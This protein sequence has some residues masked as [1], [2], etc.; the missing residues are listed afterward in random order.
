M[1][2]FD[3]DKNSSNFPA[4][5]SG[6]GQILKKLLRIAEILM[7]LLLLTWTAARLPFAVRISGEYLRR[8]VNIVVS[9]LF[10]FLLSNAI[11]LVLFCKSRSL[12]HLHHGFQDYRQT[13]ID[14]CQDFIANA[15]YFAGESCRRGQEIVYQDKRTILEVT[16]VRARS[17]RRSQSVNSRRESG[18]CGRRLRRSET[19]IRRRVGEE[20]APE[21][22]EVVDQLSN[23]EFQRAIE[24]FIAKQIKFHQ[25]EKLTIVLH[26][27]N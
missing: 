21:K 2:G 5:F 6:V 24:A 22:A 13:Q 4:G 9:H 15:A 10:I 3:F 20:A 25:D 19:E 7:V 16:K 1:E 8:L 26:E 27:C 12:F 11:V 18:A 14:F 23:E 17:H